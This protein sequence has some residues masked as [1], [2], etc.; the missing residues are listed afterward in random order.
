MACILLLFVV[1]VVVVLFCFILFCLFV[2]LFVFCFVLFCFVFFF[3]IGSGSSYFAYFVP[4]ICTKS[5]GQ[6]KLIGRLG[7]SSHPLL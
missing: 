4:R 1:V 7:Y 5:F 3:L 2:C 6:I